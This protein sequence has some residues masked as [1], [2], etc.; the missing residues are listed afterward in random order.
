MPHEPMLC[1]QVKTIDR[2]TFK[3]YGAQCNTYPCAY[4]TAAAAI[5]MTPA[6][7]E[8]YCTK[9]DATI[10]EFQRQASVRAKSTG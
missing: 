9:L 5:G 1:L 3:G 4:I 6:D 7:V 10:K 2:W 8:Q